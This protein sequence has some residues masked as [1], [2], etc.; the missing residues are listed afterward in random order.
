MS[1]PRKWPS[2]WV[3]LWGVLLL[4][5]ATALGGYRDATRETAQALLG[6]WQRIS[7]AGPGDPNELSAEH[8]EFREAGVLLTLIKDEGTDTFWLNNSA[9]Y[10]VTSSSQMLVAGTC[11]QGWERY[12]CSRTYSIRLAGDHLT[13]SADNQAEYQRIGEPSLDLPP[14]LAPPFPSPTP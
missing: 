13:I 4:G 14:T 11:W 12:A 8:I 10:T 1:K 5:L 9:T 2:T 6:K 3:L 7:P